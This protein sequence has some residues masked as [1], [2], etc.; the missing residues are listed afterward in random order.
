MTKTDFEIAKTIHLDPLM[1]TCRT[2]DKKGEL[3][4]F[5]YESVQRGIIKYTLKVGEEC[6]EL[7][8]HRQW[9]RTTISLPNKK[10]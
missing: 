7:T 8:A 9:V 4:E 2:I 3:W 10:N 5:E 6:D 1:M